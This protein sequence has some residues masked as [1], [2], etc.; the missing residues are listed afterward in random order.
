MSQVYNTKVPVVMNLIAEDGP[1]AVRRLS[2]A[3]EKAGF[4]TMTE[5]GYA[6]AFEAEEGTEP[7]DLTGAALRLTLREQ[8]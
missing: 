4:P 1:S 6:D 2:A 3:L 5:Q 7:T 8:S